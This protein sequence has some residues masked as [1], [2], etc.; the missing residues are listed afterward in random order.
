[1]KEYRISE[2]HTYEIWRMGA[3]SGN[4]AIWTSHQLIKSSV[5]VNIA[6]AKTLDTD[7]TL[8]FLLKKREDK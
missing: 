2:I 7:H 1:M 6:F 4:A 3:R 5:Q 8:L